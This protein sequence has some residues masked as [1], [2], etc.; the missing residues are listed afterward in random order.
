[1]KKGVISCSQCEDPSQ[2]LMTRLKVHSGVMDKKHQGV[3]SSELHFSQDSSFSC[4]DSVLF[5]FCHPQR[6]FD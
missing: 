3:F 2:V 1:M 4:F 6:F 5:E